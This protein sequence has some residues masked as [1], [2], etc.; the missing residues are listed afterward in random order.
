VKRR[1]YM[2]GSARKQKE[3]IRISNSACNWWICMDN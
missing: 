3:S 1:E 2:T